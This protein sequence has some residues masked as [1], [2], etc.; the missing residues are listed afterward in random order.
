MVRTQ[1]TKYIELACCKSRPCT[2]R[3]G[4]VCAAAAYALFV[5][6]GSSS[7]MLANAELVTAF[8]KSCGYCTAERG[9]MGKREGGSET[10][11]SQAAEKVKKSLKRDETLSG[12]VSAGLAGE[13]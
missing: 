5:P 4:D 10:G 6:L 9:A 13:V 2:L 3:C 11:S 7:I 12:D 1:G 8:R